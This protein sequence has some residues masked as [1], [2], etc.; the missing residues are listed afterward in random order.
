[1]AQ[2]IL[3]ALYY[4]TADPCSHVAQLILADILAQLIQSHVSP[5]IFVA[6]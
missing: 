4:C 1:V 6:I 3:E 2:L 5:L